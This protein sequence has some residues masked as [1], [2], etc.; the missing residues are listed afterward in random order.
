[1]LNLN[2]VN[3]NPVLLSFYTSTRSPRLQ[4]K[5]IDQDFVISNKS[6]FFLGL[7]LKVCF[8]TETKQV[9]SHLQIY[10]VCGKNNYLRKTSD[11]YCLKAFCGLHYLNGKT[12]QKHF[13]VFFRGL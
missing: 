1:M 2:S 6:R 3:R 13:R 10:T 11:L 7:V 9:S 12:L 4:N 8:L 5:D